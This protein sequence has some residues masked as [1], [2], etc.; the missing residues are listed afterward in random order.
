[1]KK[2]IVRSCVLITLLATLLLSQRRTPGR[3]T[4]E[5]VHVRSE[6]DV[7][8]G[9]AFF[10]PPKGT[11]KPIAI[12]WIHGWGVNFYSPT[13]VAI[14]RALAGLSYATLTANTRMH[15]IGNVLKYS[16]G[17][18]VRG[19]G[20]WGVA[21]EEVRDLATWVDFAAARSFKKVVLVGHSGGWAAVRKYQ[22]E[23]QDSRVAGVVLAS[24]AIR[25]G[26]GAD[27]PQLAEQARRLVAGGAGDDLLRIPNRSFP[28]FV[29]AATYLDTVN[30]PVEYQDFFGTKISEPAVTR[31][32]CPI[33]AFFGA[34]ESNIGTRADLDLLEASVR[35]LPRGPRVDTAM[36]ADAD[37]MYT[38][39]E[40]QVAQTIARWADTLLR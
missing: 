17:K 24:G 32:A 27:D 29:S 37:H 13:Y 22:A 20:Y 23:K 35:R 39:Q 28:S 1:M 6:D 2:G 5:I 15:D 36:I 30:T 25:Y 8:S 38:G 9:G 4:E 3:F 19:G 34:R 11:A 16:S 40:S 18:R 12:V 31:I 10:A 33:L 7:V 26:P 14:G 21:S